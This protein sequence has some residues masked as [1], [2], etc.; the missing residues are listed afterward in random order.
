NAFGIPCLASDV[1]GTTSVIKPE[2]NGKTFPL[3]RFVEDVVD[4]IVEMSSKQSVYNELCFS[5]FDMY[6]NELNWK[7]TGR[8]IFNLISSL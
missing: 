1:G 6:I 2:I 3:S 7:T 5:S 8:K 4:Y